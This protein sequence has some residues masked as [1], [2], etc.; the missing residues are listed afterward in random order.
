MVRHRLAMCH[1]PVRSRFPVLVWLGLSLMLAVGCSGGSSSDEPFGGRL[2]VIDTIPFDGGVLPI[3]A[4]EGGSRSHEVLVLFSVAPDPVTVLDG[5]VIGGLH[6]NIRFLDGALR[7]VSGLAFL[8]GRDANG[9]RPSDIDPSIDP[10]W[11]AE[12]AADDDDVLRIIY[13]TDRRLDVAEAMP[14]GQYT[15]AVE[16]DVLD[17]RGDTIVE[18]FCGAFSVGRDS[19]PPRLLESD[20]YYGEFEVDVDRDLSFHFNESIAPG[21]ILAHPSPVVVTATSSD[22]PLVPVDLP[23]ALRSVP[24]D[25]CRFVFEPD[26]PWPVSRDGREILITATILG[27]RVSDINGN[28]MASPATVVFTTRTGRALANVPV[29]PNVLWFGSVAPDGVGAVGVNGVDAGAGIIPLVDTDSD[30]IA[31][32]SDGDRLIDG[33][34]NSDVGMPSDVLIGGWM[35]PTSLWVDPPS[36]NPTPQLPFGSSV[37]SVPSY[38]GGGVPVPNS[39]NADLGTTIF[40]AD[41]ENDVLR[42]LN[43]NSALEIDR[44]PLPDPTGLAISADSGTVFVSNYS[45]NSVSVVR[46]TPNAMHVERE[47]TTNPEDPELAVGRGPRAIAAQPDGED[48]VVLNTF[49]DTLSL[50]SPANGYEVRKVV[51]SSV[52]PD[53]YDVAVT[54]RAAAYPA[55]PGTW[56]AYV[57]NRSSDSISIF[58]SGPSFPIFL[59]P[60][61]ILTVLQDSNGFPIRRPTGMQT[62]LVTGYAGEGMWYV[63][64]ED[65]SVGHIGLQAIGPPPSPYFPSP[66]PTRVFATLSRVPGLGVGASDLALADNVQLCSPLGPIGNLRRD[67]GQLRAPVRGYVV[68]DD[69]IAVFDARHGLDTGIRIPVPGIRTLAGTLKQ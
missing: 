62:D 51:A 32:A 67:V 25:G 17:R 40:I 4:P 59:G 50:L 60:D 22:N 2:L 33:S 45:R 26:E 49:D 3:E 68:V 16:T 9:A 57:T 12:I 66:S 13:D 35:T 18:G 19:Y 36:P 23:G 20:P 15:I 64:S 53:A 52:G 31:D 27:G 55:G 14:P 61:D 41:T 48:V 69:A 7:P 1:D 34:W 6:R 29:P 11:A 24:N 21:S 44:L 39:S 46:V 37:G 42:M 38:C 56:F 43:G 30:G 58:E 63:N 8:G 65:G 10:V 47:I 28:V 54:A 5:S